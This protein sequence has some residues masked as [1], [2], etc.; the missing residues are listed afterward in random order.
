LLIA[1]L[2]KFS[3]Q[4]LFFLEP[5][6]VKIRLSANSANQLG[7]QIGSRYLVSLVVRLH[8]IYDS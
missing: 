7:D 4:I 3:R 6:R 5:K 8:E 2:S 1:I